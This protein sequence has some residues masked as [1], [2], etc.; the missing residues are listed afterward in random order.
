[1]MDIN[2][3]N[4][5]IDKFYKYK[6]IL[7]DWNEKINITAL[8]EDN[9]IEIK[10]FV[11]SLTIFKLKYLHNNQK[12]IDI[13]TGGGFPGLPLKIINKTIDLTLMDSLNKRIKF[14]NHVAK[15]LNLDNVKCLHGR[16][17]EIAKNKEYREH[18]DIAV[19]RAVAR[20]N[21]LCE[22]CIPF[23]KVGGFFIAMKGPEIEE[24]LNEAKRAVEVL[25]GKI[26]EVKKV[27]LPIY[28]IDH[29]LIVIKKVNNTSTKYPRKPGI[30]KKNPI[31]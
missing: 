21:I 31:I 15:E 28:N 17:E 27:T 11:D 3:N 2:L 23:V 22:Y 24:E 14:L 4:E 6:E 12:I 10:H 1:M 30:P 8:I 19:S 5:D 13:G 26:E 9:D 20:L 18:F 25:G 16:A 7:K 29:T